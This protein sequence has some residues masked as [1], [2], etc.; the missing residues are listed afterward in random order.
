[1]KISASSSDAGTAGK[2]SAPLARQTDSE[3]A[4]EE[5]ELNKTQTERLVDRENGIDEKGKEVAFGNAQ[6]SRTES[7]DKGEGSETGLKERDLPFRAP[8]DGNGD[9]DDGAREY[10]SLDV[11]VDTAVFSLDGDK[12]L[13][14]EKFLGR[15][16]SVELSSNDL[17]SPQAFGAPE[18]ELHVGDG[19][20]LE[21]QSQHKPHGDRCR[22]RGRQT[23][24]DSRG[25]RS[26]TFK[27][28]NRS[29]VR[30]VDRRSRCK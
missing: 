16:G 18:E 22:T 14:P 17:F 12:N 29:Q 19:V 5:Q 8:T 28:R 20:Q 26:R 9:N 10:P 27:P 25:A 3:L 6:E 2:I 11:N 13:S 30:L 24:R 23:E 4:Q 21:Q 7:S 1:M 15:T